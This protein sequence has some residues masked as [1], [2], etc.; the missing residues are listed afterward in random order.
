VTV[1]PAGDGAGGPERRAASA[2]ATPQ[3][4]SIELTRLDGDVVVVRLYGEHDLATKAELAAQLEELIRASQRVIVDLSAVEYVDSAALNN[5][6]HGDKLA[7][8]QGL[9]LT[10]QIGSAA[11][12]A[13]LLD[14]TGLRDY[15]ALAGSRDDA[16]RL[17]RSITDGA[18]S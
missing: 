6:V 16:I 14:L 7:R 13:T 18:G 15:L 11:N 8:A 4:G 2:P 10:V 1:I 5:L 3:C 9:R 17:A 12:V